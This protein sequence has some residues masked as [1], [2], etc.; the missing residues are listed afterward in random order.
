MSWRTLLGLPPTLRSFA[1][2]LIKHARRLGE[3]DWYF[4]A[5][6][7]PRYRVDTFPSPAQLGELSGPQLNRK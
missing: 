7:P 4:D 6:E 5:A 1:A 3:P 2:D